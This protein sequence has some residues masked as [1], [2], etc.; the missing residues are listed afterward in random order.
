MACATNTPTSPPSATLRALV[1]GS[2]AVSEMVINP[3]ITT[4][5]QNRGM[6][7]V[8]ISGGLVRGCSTQRQRVRDGR[9]ARQNNIE[10]GNYARSR[11][12][13]V[14]NTNG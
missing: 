11:Q 9:T 14:F 13:G 3:H 4:L 10:V 6:C 2:E 12:V 1:T 5:R 7:Y 8:C